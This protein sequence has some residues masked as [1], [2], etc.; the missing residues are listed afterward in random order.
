MIIR[1]LVSLINAA[2]F[3]ALSVTAFA[4]DEGFVPVDPTKL[5]TVSGKNLMIAAYSVIF[6]LLLLY[7]FFLGR[8]DRKVKNEV[9][10]LKKR[11]SH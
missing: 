4:Q 11:L 7:V 2:V 3:S 10:S 6:G 8:R 9:N 1:T 5:N